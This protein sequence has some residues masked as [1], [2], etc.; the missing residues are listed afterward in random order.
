MT[1]PRIGSLLALCLVGC[2]APK[3]DTLGRMVPTG[4]PI[5]LDA[6]AQSDAVGLATPTASAAPSLAPVALDVRIVTL[7]IA[8]SEPRVLATTVRSALPQVRACF[9]KAAPKT[10]RW[11]DV[12]LGV[13]GAGAPSGVKTKGDLAPEIGACAEKIFGAL[14][15][16]PKQ[17]RAAAT[18]E[19]GIRFS[20]VDESSRPQLTKNDTLFR[21]ADGS[22]LA[23]EVFT[24]PPNKSCAA[25][26]E[27]PIACPNEFGLAEIAKPGDAEKRLDVSAS[28]G[29]SGQAGERVAL[30]RIG[31]RCSL[32]KVVGIGEAGEAAASQE[33]VDLPCADFDRAFSLAE[34]SFQGAKPT[35]AK[36]PNALTRGVSLSRMGKDSV[37]VVSEVR[38]TG[39]N[40]KLDASF[41][42]LA[43]IVAKA[44]KGRGALALARFVE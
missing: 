44:A 5:S 28:G 31:D 4:A 25:P 11:L 37:P 3:Q 24:C 40:K 30:S 1:R 29:K 13:D 34:R 17:G 6:P 27:R 18:I 22:C 8:G 7:R 2:G 35:T 14:S 39:D 43:G 16:E 33:L 38:W 41:D 12:T 23:L 21:S 42:E 20:T 26:R 19:I 9:E 32:L 15:F 10:A 36:A